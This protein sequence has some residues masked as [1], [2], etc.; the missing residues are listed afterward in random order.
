MRGCMIR[1]LVVASLLATGLVAQEPEAAK[2]MSEPEF[3]SLVQA[4]TPLEEIVAEVQARGIAFRVTPDLE[5]TLKKMK[6]KNMEDLLE[7]LTAPATVEIHTNVPGARV[8]LDA[9]ERGSVSPEGE[10]VL[11]G[12]PAGRHLVRLQAE[13]HVSDRVDIFLKPGGTQR[14]EMELTSAIM[15]K[16]GPL[17]RQ[18]SVQAGTAEDSALVELEFVKDPQARAQKLQDLIQRYNHSPLALLAYGML[19]QTYLTNGQYDEAIAAGEEILQRDPQNFAARM[20]S[21][22]ACRGKGEL[23][24]AFDYAAQARQQVEELRAAPA[25]AG[26][27][28]DAWEREKTSL[29]EEAEGELGNLAYDLFLAAS[30]EPDPARKSA[31]LEKFVELFPQSDYS[32][33]AFVSLA[34]AYQQQ[35]KAEKMLVWADKALEANPNEPVALVLV[36]DAL[37]D[38][39]QR[40]DQARELGTRL[41][42]LLTNEP[43]KVRP[44]GL[45]DEQWAAQRQLWEGLAHSAL[46]QVLLHEE[47]TEEAL[48]ELRAASPA[49]KGEKQLYARNLYRLGF[50]Y[51][52][53]GGIQNMERAREVLNELVELGTAYAPPGRDLLQRVN[54][55]LAKAGR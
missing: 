15:S 28:P 43:E 29:L 41:L 27:A 13:G 47:N 20:R 21:A 16:P 37:S 5:E 36:S 7:A 54:Q 34:V 18:V 44:Q 2:P 33:Q 1:L 6:A 24:A 52:K 23:E 45:S 11:T 4:K 38:R 46:G 10:L 53:L 35:G 9:E 50:A 39:G 26:T 40:L 42:D 32:P 22:R 49:L 48:G 30:A 19:Q 31:F 8:T 12:V 17:G 25:P 55:A 3:L 51:A 14:V